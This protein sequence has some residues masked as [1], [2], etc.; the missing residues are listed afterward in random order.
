MSEQVAPTTEQ[1][2]LA[3]Y[4]RQLAEIELALANAARDRV[5]REDRGPEGRWYDWMLASGW[6]LAVIA[7]TKLFL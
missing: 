7:V 5:E 6:T 3:A 2:Q 4:D 1:Q